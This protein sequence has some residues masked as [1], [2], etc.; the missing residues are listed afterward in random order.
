MADTRKI[1]H[2][3]VNRVTGTTQSEIN[4]ELAKFFMDV[5]SS[6]P[7]YDELKT[8]QIEINKGILVI[9]NNID[10]PSIY[11]MN[12]VGDVVK[13]SGNGSKSVNTYEDALDEATNDNIGRIYYVKSNS[14]YNNQSYSMGPYIVVGDGMLKKLSTSLASGDV[15]TVIMGLENEI[16]ILKGLLDKKVDSKE[17]YTLI[18]DE[19][20]EKLTNIE[21]G[22]Q[23]NTIEKIIVNGEPL[24]IIDK[25]VSFTV[26]VGDDVTDG[27][28]DS[29]TIED[30]DGAKYLVF[31][32]TDAADKEP[33]MVNISEMYKEEYFSGNGISLENQAI[34]VRLGENESILTFDIDGNLIMSDIFVTKIDDIEDKVINLITKVDSNLSSI[35]MMINGMKVLEVDNYET[36][37]QRATSKNIGQIIKTKKDSQY[38]TNEGVEK[39][40]LEGFYLVKGEGQLFFIVTSDGTKDEIIELVRNMEDQFSTI[41]KYTVN[42]Q[43]IS[44]ENGIVLEGKDIVVDRN[45][46]ES[47]YAMDSVKEGDTVNV[48]V[49]KIENSLAATVIATTASL[50]DMNSQIN[51]PVDEVEYIENNII[52]KPNVFHIISTPISNLSFSLG[53]SI[54][55]N[56][57]AYRYSILFSTSN[58]IDAVSFPPVIKYSNIAFSDLET[59]TTYLLEIQYNFAKWTKMKELNK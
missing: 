48:A 55:M 16:D 19:N 44:Q 17:G 25:A 32:F 54:E 31:T 24:P 6:H 41:N 28:V 29:V 42:G 8:E 22:A 59:D 49:K 37:L 56:T 3:H 21:N 43:L 51:W 47:S 13:I 40:Y 33:I 30:I 11:V 1:V 14:V 52:L 46:E 12:T 7:F 35:N 58:V 5:Q 34:A 27:R 57:I 2:G 10:D 53:E 18:S 36:A 39:T 20:A 4:S 23:S 9:N 26:L 45:F 50:N 15:E 38:I